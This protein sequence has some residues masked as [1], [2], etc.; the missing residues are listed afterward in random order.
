MPTALI[1]V[2]VQNDFTEGGNLPVVGGADVAARISSFLESHHAHFALVCASQDWHLPGS[3]N[4]GHFPPD[5]QAP[6]FHSTW[7]RHCLAGSQGADF[8]PHLDRT[9]IQVDVKKGLG[10]PAYSAFQGHTDEDV[11]L[12]RL[13]LAAGITRVVV[14][15]LATDYCV[16]Q[17]VMDAHA[18]KYD[19]TLLQDLSAGVAE[20]TT[21]RA[22]NDMRRVGASVMTSVE[23]AG[24]CEAIGE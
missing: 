14:C 10:A 11:G 2:D 3:S 21:L 1:V 5:G 7:P 22:L 17:T 6:D 23:Y 24:R 12:E 13:L 19:V 18:L 15:G 20:D 16:H 4:G 8:H 9:H